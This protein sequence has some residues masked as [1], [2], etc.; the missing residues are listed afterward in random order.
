M[1][2]SSTSQPTYMPRRLPR[3]YDIYYYFSRFHF[4]YFDMMMMPHAKSPLY[5][6]AVR[7]EILWRPDEAAELAGAFERPCRLIYSLSILRYFSRLTSAK[8]L[9]R[10]QARPPAHSNL[11]G[12]ASRQTRHLFPHHRARPL[13]R[14]IYF[15]ITSV[16]YYIR[17]NLLATALRGSQPEIINDYF[18]SLFI[19]TYTYISVTL[20]TCGR[21]LAMNNITFSQSFSSRRALSRAKNSH[22]DY[23]AWPHY[24]EAH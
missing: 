8:R 12:A 19:Y 21:L 9:A 3:R 2:P 24:A 5:S 13:L 10:P 22:S 7:D 1:P 18:I 11:A 15:I 17:Y 23:A 6:R 16:I 14:E 4:L 20:I